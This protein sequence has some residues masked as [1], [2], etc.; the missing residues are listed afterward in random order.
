MDIHR[1]A[2]SAVLQ[3]SASGVRQ[4][5]MVRGSPPPWPNRRK[6][7]AS[8][9]NFSFSFSSSLTKSAPQGTEASCCHGRLRRARQ[10]VGRSNVAQCRAEAS[11]EESPSAALEH[12]AA[13]AWSGGVFCR[14]GASL[15]APPS[16]AAAASTS[17][18]Y[19]EN[20]GQAPW[21]APSSP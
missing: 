9:V 11:H 19:V 7:G 13:V 10:L 2:R 6:N 16:L 15:C 3:S 1:N 14:L 8:R 21:P 20:C 18:L 4:Y 17:S 5:G 12:R